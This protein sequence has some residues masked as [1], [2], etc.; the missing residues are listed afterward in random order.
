[1]LTA[2]FHH[3]IWN[4]HGADRLVLQKAFASSLVDQPRGI[5]GEHQAWYEI[6][7]AAQKQL[8][9]GSDGPAFD[10]VEDAVCQ[11]RQ[12]PRSN[13]AAAHDTTTLA[14]EACIGR[15]GESLAATAFEVADRCS[16]T[17]VWWGNPYVRTMCTADPT[18][19]QQP[20]GYLL[21][22]WMARYYGF[23]TADQ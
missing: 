9:P 21:P 13:H 16:G 23:V 1:M 6:M 5:T 10:A 2:S 14:P 7:W 15:S 12:F 20:A 3:L 19:V 11:L 22:Y 8:G 18:L 17:F 4:V